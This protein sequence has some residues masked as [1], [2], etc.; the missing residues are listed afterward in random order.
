MPLTKAKIRELRDLARKKDR[1]ATGLFVVDGVRGVREA[2]RSGFSMVELFYS[3]ALLADPAGSA[4]VEEAKRRTRAVHAVTPREMEQISD[5]MTAQ[6]V[7]AVM[8]QR[9]W[10]IAEVLHKEDRASLIVALDA[11]ADPGN[12]GAIIRTCDWFGV[13]ALILGENSVDLYNPKVVRSTVGSIFHLPILTDIELPSLVSLVK[14]F[15]YTVYATA[16]DGVTY[17]DDMHYARKALFLLGNEAWGISDPV[18]QAADVR[19][20]VRR[21]GAAESLNVGVACGVLLA[22]VRRK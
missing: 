21:H 5:T 8:Q 15:G 9:E 4:I 20:A 12:L 7:L 2:L 22:S 17:T 13:D 18:M 11:V 10:A 19:L 16:A 6:G 1:E 14:G 3:G